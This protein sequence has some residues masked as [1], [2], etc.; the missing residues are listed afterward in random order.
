MMSLKKSLFYAQR[1]HLQIVKGE[2]DLTSMAVCKSL[3]PSFLWVMSE[4]HP[5]CLT[6]I[7][8]HRA[9]DINR[10]PTSSRTQSRYSHDR[11]CSAM[12]NTSHC[13]MGNSPA[14]VRHLFVYGKHRGGKKGKKL[15]RRVA[16]RM[17]MF[18]TKMLKL[19]K[20]FCCLLNERK[21]KPIA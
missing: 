20:L 8:P 5:C 7:C 19:R 10:N 2:A 6:G 11:T 18:S 9:V 15:W 12:R 14:L 1:K 13:T 4:K 3:T 16:G 17:R 21:V